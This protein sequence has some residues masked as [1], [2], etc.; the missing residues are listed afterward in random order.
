MGEDHVPS[1]S[2][3]N[4]PIEAHREAANISQYLKNALDL[5][6]RSSGCLFSLTTTNA[7]A[8][9]YFLP[10][11]VRDGMGFSVAKAECLVALPHTAAGFV[12]FFYA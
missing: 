3:Q 9:A 5:K 8:T 4:P 7:Y 11:I 2:K 12:M 1:S 6:T 10:I